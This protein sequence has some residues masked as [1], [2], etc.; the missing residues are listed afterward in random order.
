M[1]V[2]FHY[3]LAVFLERIMTIPLAARAQVRILSEGVVEP[4]GRCDPL[5]ADLNPTIHFTAEQ[6]REGLPVF[7]AFGLRDLRCCVSR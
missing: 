2:W 3:A 4:A 1:P 7:E 6:I 5:P